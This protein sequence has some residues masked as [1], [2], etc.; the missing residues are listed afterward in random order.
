MNKFLIAFLVLVMA[1]LACGQPAQEWEL[2][3]WT[4]TPPPFSSTSTPIAPTQTPYIIQI[5]NTPEST[6]IPTESVGKCVNATESVYLRPSAGND[7]YPIMP[8]PNGAILY[9]LGGR[10]GNWIFVRY[11]DKD[12]WVNMQYVGV[13]K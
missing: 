1:M 8:L 9:D 5:T 12:G 3:G 2:R 6:P 7:N 10:S 11:Q 13:C 4:V